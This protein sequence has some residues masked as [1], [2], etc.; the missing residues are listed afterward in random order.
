MDAKLYQITASVL[1][2]LDGWN[3]TFPRTL[4]QADT[5][6]EARDN[7]DR[8]MLQYENAAAAVFMLLI[9]PI[10][11]PIGILYMLSA[12][13]VPPIMTHSIFLPGS[14]LSDHLPIFYWSQYNL[15]EIITHIGMFNA[16]L[17]SSMLYLWE[18]WQ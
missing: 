2:N 6:E 1:K 5:V 13:F 17:A 12:K 18:Y 10:Y 7:I 11:F 4:K 16:D 15:W 14:E 3:T 9:S 8:E